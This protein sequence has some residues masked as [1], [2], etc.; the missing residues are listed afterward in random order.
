MTCNMLLGSG[1][2]RSLSLDLHYVYTIEHHFYVTRLRSKY[3][4]LCLVSNV[5]RQ[6]SVTDRN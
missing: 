3:L 4:H 6:S 5:A 1:I 2:C